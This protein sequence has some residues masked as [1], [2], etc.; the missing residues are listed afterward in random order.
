MKTPFWK[1]D[2]FLGLVITIALFGFARVSGLI[3]GVE[4]IGRAHV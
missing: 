1:A 3:P 2:W 4:Q